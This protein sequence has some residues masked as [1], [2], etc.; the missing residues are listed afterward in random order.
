[1]T[2]AHTK[3][4]RKNLD[5]VKKFPDSSVLYRYLYYHPH[6]SCVHCTYVRTVDLFNLLFL[7][8]YHFKLSPPELL[9]LE[10][11]SIIDNNIGILYSA[12]NYELF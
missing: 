6:F 4:Q 11:S 2:H 9:T 5:E 10:T 3:N 1:M 12:Y 7:L 8:K